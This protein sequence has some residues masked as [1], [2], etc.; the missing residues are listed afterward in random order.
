M[1]EQLPHTRLNLLS[2]FHQL[3]FLVQETKSLR[4]TLI[5]FLT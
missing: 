4:I 2:Y 5:F 1:L 3:V